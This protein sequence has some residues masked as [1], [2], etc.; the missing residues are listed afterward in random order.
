MLFRSNLDNPDVYYHSDFY[1]QVPVITARLSFLRL[2]DQLIREGKMEKARVALDFCNK[3]MP[4]KAIPYDQLSANFV[5]LYIGAGDT[6]KGLQMADTIMNRNNQ[7]LD[8]YLNDRRGS[9]SQAI[10]SNLYEMQIVVEGLKNAKLPEA[11]KYDAMLQ[12]QLARAN[13]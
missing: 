9:D 12:K 8:Y 6:K 10:Q 11:V 2:I 4:D 5:A 1:L 3:V 7:A 13:S